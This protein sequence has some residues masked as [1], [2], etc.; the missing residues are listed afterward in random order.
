[1]LSADDRG[2]YGLCLHPPE[3]Q[4]FFVLCLFRRVEN[5]IEH[6]EVKQLWVRQLRRCRSSRQVRHGHARSADLKLFV[7]SRRS[8]QAP[9][10]RGYASEQQASN[11]G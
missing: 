4:E 2:V 6:E 7:C 1:M 8:P 10:C 9:V 3:E 5:R 11:V